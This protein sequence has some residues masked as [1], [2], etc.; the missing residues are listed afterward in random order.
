MGPGNELNKVMKEKDEPRISTVRIGQNG[1][2]SDIE[3]ILESG[4]KAEAGVLRLRDAVASRAS[5]NGMLLLKGYVFGN[6]DNTKG[7]ES[8]NNFKQE[9]SL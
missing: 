1:G 5:L 8:N 7:N 4:G 3:N 9:L 2:I 6:L